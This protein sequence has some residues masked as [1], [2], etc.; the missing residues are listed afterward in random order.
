MII[1]RSR[2]HTVNLSNYENVKIGASVELGDDDYPKNV[3]SMPERS[4]YAN[5]VL[6]ALL[7]RDLA[8]ALA[9]VP[10]G[11]PTHLESWGK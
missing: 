11:K 6:D 10:E 3:V 8:E 5:T 9:N 4:A 2:E 1:K 7:K